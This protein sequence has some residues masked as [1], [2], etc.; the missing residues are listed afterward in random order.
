MEIK[1]S[2]VSSADIVF[3]RQAFLAE[4]DFQFIYDKC[5]LY[6]WADCFLY[7]AGNEQV[8]YGANWAGKTP[9][10]RD[11]VFEFFIAKPYRKY[12]SAIFKKHFEFSKAKYIECQSNDHFLTQL[13][14]EHTKNIEADRIL[15]EDDLTTNL[16]VAG[17]V[18]ERLPSDN[19]R[20][21]KFQLRLENEVVA[22]G[23]FMLNYNF[24]YADIYYE[25]NEK[26]RGK[27]I[28]S[29]LAQELKKEVYLM[30]RV[31][32]A[33]CNIDNII[34]KA[35]LLRSGFR[36]CGYMLLGEIKTGKTN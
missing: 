21:V 13:L 19:N 32:A 10:T 7:T 34:S 9:D 30:G 18:L 24:P 26:S 6:G 3:L 33:R 17:A 22:Y 11:A 23:G 8:G 1:V 15:F 4:N 27:G 14:Y 2:K 5:H 20:D 31:P 16:Q 25:I 28:G 12:T 29:Y 35:T 36:I